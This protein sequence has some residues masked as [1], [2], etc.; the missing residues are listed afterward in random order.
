[1]AIP[2]L[3]VV[4]SS[5]VIAAADPM[6]VHHAASGNALR[7]RET[8]QWLMPISVLAESLVVP[9]RQGDEEVA[10]VKDTLTSIFGDCR[11]LDE[12][13][14]VASARLRAAYRWLRL[15]DALVLAVADVD[16]ADE[17]LTCDQRWA[18]V[19]GRVTVVGDP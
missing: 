16:G 3:I 4:D 14:A 17:V 10:A 18:K 5:V 1:M 12:E 13:I 15:P 6:D 11:V 7:S 9:A 2:P 8:M 19:S